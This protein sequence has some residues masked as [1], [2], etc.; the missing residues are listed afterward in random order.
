MSRSLGD[1]KYH[2][3]GVSHKPGN[4]DK[5]IFNNSIRNYITQIFN[6]RQIHYHCIRWSLGVHIKRRS[7]ILLMIYKYFRP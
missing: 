4:I 5:L 3:I 1:L 6:G 7:I 2:N